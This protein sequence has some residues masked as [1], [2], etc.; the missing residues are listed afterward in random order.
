MRTNLGK[1][2]HYLSKIK[3][4][5]K[6]FIDSIIKEYPNKLYEVSSNGEI[7]EKNVT[8][9]CYNSRLFYTGEKPT[10]KDVYMIKDY[11]ENMPE[12]TIDKILICTE[13]IDHVYSYITSSAV[14]Y[15]RL[16][17]KFFISKKDAEI[18]SK[19]LLNIKNKEEELLNNGHIRCTYC[20]KIVPEKDAVDY[21]IIFQNSRPDPF[22]RTGYKRFVDNKIN[23]YCSKTCGLHD[24][25]AHEG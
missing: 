13:Y 19:E 16:N 20:K 3:E 15:N 14:S 5:E 22:S 25:M 17:D 24:Q 10:R 21:K 7:I 9:I 1:W 12:L 4:T 11:Y 8:E 2:N 23:K 18:K 6:E